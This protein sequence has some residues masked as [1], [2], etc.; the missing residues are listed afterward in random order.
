MNEIC[1]EFEELFIRLVINNNVNMFYIILRV[2]KDSILTLK[3][4][5]RNAQEKIV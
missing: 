5:D 2:L 4:S 1:N 3:Q